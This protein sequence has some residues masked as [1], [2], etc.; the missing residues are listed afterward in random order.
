MTA[1]YAFAKKEWL[2]Q[3]RSGRLLLLLLI[4]L[5]LGVM[6]P[7]VAKFTPWLV[8]VLAEDL[9]ESGMTVGA[10][11]VDA[12]TSWAQFDKNIPLGLIVFVLLQGAVFTREY[13][14]GTLILPLTRGLGRAQIVLAK[15]LLL[16]LLWTLC[17]W[18]CFVVTWGYTAYYWDNSI[19]QH[20]TAAAVCWWLLGLWAVSM[21][22]LCS[23]LLPSQGGVLLG[24]GGGFLAAY[25][26]GLLPKLSVWSPSALMHP[27][28]LL[29][30]V[31][32]PADCGRAMV[33]TILLCILSVA[34]SIPLLRRRQ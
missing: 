25:L 1:L 18:L 32:T 13:Q 11:T 28:L 12:M 15:T 26:L 31:E 17:Y 16:A 6:S 5:L 3:L 20:L 2:E 34:A 14:A 8:E 7:A 23:A 29:R 4:F 19:V 24:V 22:A 33:V 9:A 10:V 30:G 27:A 21:I